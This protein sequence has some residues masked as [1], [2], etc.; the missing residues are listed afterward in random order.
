MHSG[1]ECRA[2]DATD[3]RPGN[4]RGLYAGPLESFY[5]ADMRQALARAEMLREKNRSRAMRR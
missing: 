4:D 3:T 5:D 2:N 1:G